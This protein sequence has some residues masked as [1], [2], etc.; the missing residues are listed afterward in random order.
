MGA[1]IS[2]RKRERIIQLY[3]GRCYLCG[4]QCIEYKLQNTG[5][6]HPDAL[7]IDHVVSTYLGGTSE[8]DNLAVACAR[9]NNS[10]CELG[11]GNERGLDL[12]RLH[13]LYLIP[14]PYTR[15]VDVDTKVLIV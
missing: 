12:L 1:K 5:Y 3:G 9:C 2:G 6:Q 7:T 8:D 15:G 10:K 11:L 4:I 13:L 14:F